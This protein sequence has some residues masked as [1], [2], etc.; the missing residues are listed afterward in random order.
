MFKTL[1]FFLKTFYFNFPEILTPPESA[2]KKGNCKIFEQ[3]GLTRSD[4]YI[5]V[6]IYVYYPSKRLFL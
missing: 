3:L 2:E 1:F 4:I 5:F 6:C